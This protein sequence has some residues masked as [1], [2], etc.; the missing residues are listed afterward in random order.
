MTGHFVRGALPCHR[1]G[2]DAQTHVSA[3]IR[4]GEI[5]SSGGEYCAHCGMAQEWDGGELDD[6]LRELFCEQE[7]RWAVFLDDLGADRV[8]ALRVLRDLLDCQPSDLPPLLRSSAPLLTGALVEVERLHGVLT[9]TGASCRIER[10][11]DASQ[12]PEGCP[13]GR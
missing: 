8:A 5:H 7:G 10:V 9:A 12:A 11:A 2:S 6:E 4:N 13:S 3:R 1:C